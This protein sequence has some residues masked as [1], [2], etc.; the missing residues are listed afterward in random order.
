MVL[1]DP[2]LESNLGKTH[3]D[4]SRPSSDKNRQSPASSS[5]S[6]EKIIDGDIIPSKSRRSSN[7]SQ[8]RTTIT[9]QKSNLPSGR[10]GNSGNEK[11]LSSRQNSSEQNKKDSRRS[12]TDTDTLLK[13][14]QERALSNDKR[15]SPLQKRSGQQSRKNST[16]TTDQ[17][18]VTPITTDSKKSEKVTK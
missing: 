16:K 5:V 9:D 10:K 11:K 3:Q 13:Q 15:K 8:Q 12:S 6:N 4:R 2:V 17:T 18:V 14:K 1:T 7:I